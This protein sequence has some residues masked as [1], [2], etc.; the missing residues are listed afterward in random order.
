M[1]K[2]PQ[3][4]E[5]E[6]DTDV[7]EPSADH[8]TVEASLPTRI[9]RFAVLRK[10]GQ[11]GM[12]IV[13][14]A[15]D[16]EL[17]RRVAIKI[18]RRVD[19]RSVNRMRREA[20]AMARVSHPNV[21]HVYEVGT[22]EGQ[23]YIALEFIK[24]CTFREWCE[25][26]ARSE[27]EIIDVMRQAGE[28]LQAAHDVGLVHRDFKPDNIMV[29]KDG[30]VRVLDFGLAGAEE[31]GG[32]RD[33]ETLESQIQAIAQASPLNSP[34]TET[35][36]VMGTPAYMS[37]EQFF[38]EKVGP[39]SDQFSFCVSLYEALYGER[40]FDGD[41]VISI[42]LNVAQGKLKAA[43]AGATVSA[44]TRAG[45]VRGLATKP[46]DRFPDMRALL[47]ALPGTR[48][49]ADDRSVTD[50]MLW[51]IAA[52]AVGG[53]G[54]WAM[55][56][57]TIADGLQGAPVKLPGFT[58][59]AT[60]LGVGSLGIA[61]VGGG[62]AAGLNAWA[63]R[64]PSAPRTVHQLGAFL[65][66]GQAVAMVFFYATGV[67]PWQWEALAFPF[68]GLATL[69]LAA[70]A[71]A[72][73]RTRLRALAWAIGAGYGLPSLA[74]F[75]A[76]ETSLSSFAGGTGISSM[77]VILVAI[78]IIVL[79]WH[80]LSA[81]QPPSWAVRASRGTLAL[82]PGLTL[83]F[84]LTLYGSDS[85]PGGRATITA[86]PGDL[87]ATHEMGAA[88]DC[89]GCVGGE[90]GPG[91]EDRDGIALLVPG[92]HYAM[93]RVEV[94]GVSSEK[95]TLRGVANGSE[96][97]LGPG[98]FLLPPGETPLIVRN[99][100]PRWGR[101]PYCVGAWS[102]ELSADVVLTG[103]QPEALVPVEFAGVWDD[104][105]DQRND[106]RSRW[107][108]TVRGKAPLGASVR[109]ELP[110]PFVA[111]AE[112]AN[113]GALFAED[114]ERAQWPSSGVRV[115]LIEDE[116]SRWFEAVSEN[117]NWEVPVEVAGE[118]WRSMDDLPRANVFHSV[119]RVR[120]VPDRR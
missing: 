51:T 37:S 41:S 120:L 111:H 38:S 55:P 50:N 108:T 3:P 13:Y 12:G 58:G 73:A 65:L 26:E 89:P 83:A 4:P 30:R 22:W 66:L 28:A 93:V 105:P 9:G 85:L 101:R 95:V 19:E 34:L 11:G 54:L 69:Y 1:S 106:I 46:E 40:P 92:A 75:I 70:P 114:D 107:S 119:L 99:D 52:A 15:F 14:S 74:L 48:R 118:M 79:T 97:P 56:F 10:L 84:V 63:R 35:G 116:P 45:L 90:L 23:L 44:T 81:D 68:V 21:A 43:P 8:G 61:A 27:Q 71:I 96:T 25:Q 112:G 100:G 98:L 78:V 49:A 64:H 80:W 29:G 24:G 20:Q 88:C 82:A 76:I 113:L 53:V 36:T 31:G 17:D 39:A 18:L 16:E 104:E 110:D 57:A 59:V 77:A 94:E 47:E 42:G 60:G 91:I 117:G 62:V 2:Q 5:E 86:H 87:L 103:E 109:V 6:T 67:F 115:E 33:L 72:L 102:T 7:T 32:R